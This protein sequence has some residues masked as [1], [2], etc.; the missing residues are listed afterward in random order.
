MAVQLSKKEF[1]SINKPIDLARGLP[2]ACYTTKEWEKADRET[3]LGKHWTCLGYC[4]DLAPTDYKTIEFLGIPLIIISD[5]T[6]ICR[7]FHNVCRHRGHKLLDSAGSL[8]G[9]IRCPYH[10]WTYRL[11]GMLMA[12]PHIG[13]FGIHELEGEY[14]SHL[15]LLEVRSYTWLGLIFINLSGDAIEFSD[16]IGPLRSRWSSFLGIEGFSNL[17]FPEA[18]DVIELRVKA[19]WKLIVENYCE[20]YHLPWVHPN[21]SRYS[22]TK[23]HYNIVLKEL[24]SGQGTKKFSFAEEKEISLPKFPNWPAKKIDVAEYIALYPNLLLGI[25]SD[26]VF[27]IIVHPVKNDETLESILIYYP[28]DEIIGSDYG[29]ARRE[30]MTGWLAVF[31]QDIKPLEGMQRGRESGAFDGGIFSPIQEISTHAFH[32]WL[33]QRYPQG[34]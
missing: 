8:N 7:V 24:G 31:Q 15:G 26:H 32:C 12:T 13:G 28:N 10:S 6:G 5:E 33:A 22:Q 29:D 14:K 30:I 27:A 18:N 17:I 21:L 1:D 16:Y 4:Y 20:S 34:D 19:N 11:D 25:H 3:S 2:S 23:D 9:A